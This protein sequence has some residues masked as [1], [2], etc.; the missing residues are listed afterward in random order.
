MSTLRSLFDRV[1][2]LCDRDEDDGSVHI[3]DLLCSFRAELELLSKASAKKKYNTLQQYYLW[4]RE[5]ASTVD[6]IERRLLELSKEIVE[7][8]RSAAQEGSLMSR[9]IEVHGNSTVLLRRALQLL[10]ENSDRM[11]ATTAW[12]ITEVDENPIYM[13][14]L[15]KDMD[16]L[17]QFH[18]AEILSTAAFGSILKSMSFFNDCLS[19]VLRKWPTRA[20]GITFKIKDHMTFDEEII[21]KDSDVIIPYFSLFRQLW[22]D[23]PEKF[24]PHRWHV[25][26][27]QYDAMKAAFA[28]VWNADDETNPFQCV[29]LMHLRMLLFNLL[30]HF[31][32]VIT[33]PGIP[34]FVNTLTLQDTLV[35]FRNREKSN[36]A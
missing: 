19:E 21:E 34:C 9:I 28:I 32:L 36:Q 26:H 24:M 5:E 35:S 33:A 25:S 15:Q 4:G 30:H 6:I 17:L 29:E 22:I 11:A 13:R 23:R 16:E 20:D 31:D 1:Y 18:G 3:R 8:C 10:C 14:G 7:L 12:F 27:H 2:G